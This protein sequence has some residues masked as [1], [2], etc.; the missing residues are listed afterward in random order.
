MRSE[1]KRRFAEDE[2]L[3]YYEENYSKDMDEIKSELRFIL[4]YLF[5]NKN[6][7]NFIVE[8]ERFVPVN[9]SFRQA[10]SLA[11]NSLKQDKHSKKK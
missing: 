1:I 2:T 3:G 6:S 9:S 4:L 7:I 11:K 10:W 5:P 8:L